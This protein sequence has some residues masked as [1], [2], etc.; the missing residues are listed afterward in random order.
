VISRRKGRIQA[1]EGAVPTVLDV[2]KVT[3]L[4]SAHP[5]INKP[6]CAPEQV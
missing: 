2:T 3:N 5:R 4:L 6:F 1:A